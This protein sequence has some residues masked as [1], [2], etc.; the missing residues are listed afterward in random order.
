MFVQSERK[1]WLVKQSAKGNVNQRLLLA[2]RTRNLD[3]IFGKN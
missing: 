2:T 1:R 3:V